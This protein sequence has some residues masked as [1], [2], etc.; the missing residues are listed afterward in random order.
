MKTKNKILTEK[1]KEEYDKYMNKQLN[2][3]KT[4][5]ERIML[6]CYN[7]FWEIAYKEK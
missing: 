6:R 1:G 4:H 5:H 3:L 2:I 7:K